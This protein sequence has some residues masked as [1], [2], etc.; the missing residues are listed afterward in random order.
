MPWYEVR[1]IVAKVLGGLEL[2]IVL[3]DLRTQQYID[4]SYPASMKFLPPVI[5]Q[6]CARQL[7]VPVAKIRWF[8]KLVL[9]ELT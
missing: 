2:T 3:K 6:Y 4:I 7:K 8:H 1:G 5:L 9:P